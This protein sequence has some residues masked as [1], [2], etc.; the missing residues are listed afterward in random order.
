M[1][2]MLRNWTASDVF[3][4]VVVGALTVMA[5]CVWW[6]SAIVPGMDYPQFLV[7]V[8]AV[9]DHADPT[10]PFHGTYTVGPWFVPTSLPIHLVSGLS[11][12]FGHSIERGGKM[13]MTAQSVGL[14][15]SSLFLLNVL[16]RPRWAVVALFQSFTRSGRSWAGLPRTRRRFPSSCSGGR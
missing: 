5:A 10:S 2:G 15:A 9:Q 7:F 12:L 3:F 16:G 11:V 6:L 8:R 13:L 1:P 4:G 14:V